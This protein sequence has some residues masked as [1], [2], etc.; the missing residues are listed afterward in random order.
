MASDPEAIKVK[1]NQLVQLLESW[2]PTFT[3]S[4][5][6]KITSFEKQEAGHWGE[7]LRLASR[8]GDC[9]LNGQRVPAVFLSSVK[10]SIGFNQINV[11]LEPYSRSFYIT[12]SIG[13]NFDKKFSINGLE[14]NTWYKMVLSQR[15]IGVW[16]IPYE[17]WKSSSKNFFFIIFFSFF[18]TTQTTF[19]WMDF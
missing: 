2:G 15:K 7:I 10:C 13:N 12:T 17:H 6:I 3:I 4:V 5:E 1:K 9:C 14:E 18:I 16:F 19:S 8:P 11:V